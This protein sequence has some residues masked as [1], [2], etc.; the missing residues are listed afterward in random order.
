MPQASSG[1]WREAP[2]RSGLEGCMTIVDKSMVTPIQPHTARE[3]SIDP[4][5]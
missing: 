3:W 2:A 4:E 1:A 5:N